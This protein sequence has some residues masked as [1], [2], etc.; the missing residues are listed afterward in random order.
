VK[1]VKAM[2]VLRT[3]LVVMLGAVAIGTTAA[4]NYHLLKRIPVSG[5]EDRW[6]YIAMDTAGRRVYFSYGPHV[7]V[8]DADSN[9]LVGRIDKAPGFVHGIAIAPELSRGFIS[10]GGAGSVTIFNTKT[11]EVLGEVKVTGENPDAIVYDPP[12]HR[13]FTFNARSHNATA[14]DAKTDEVVGSVDLDGQSEFARSDA[15]GHVFVDLVD[16]GVVLQIDSQKLKAMGR[17]PTGECKRP[18]SMAIDRKSKRLFIGCRNPALMTVLDS[19]DGH[20]ITTVPIGE[21]T[22]AAEFDPGT[23]RVF[24]SNTDGTVTVIHQESPDKYTVVETVKTEVQA[25]T[26]AVDLKTHKLFLSLSDR[27]PPKPNDRNPFGAVIPGTFR[28]LVFGT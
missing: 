20:V 7:L 14:I 11:Q 28:I 27:E 21:G 18:T 10:N 25:R 26:I 17:W 13:V 5:I 15:E 1:G 16:K 8:M 2:R 19:N 3:L 24:C 6:D 12:T 23:H 4:G 9:T 22:D